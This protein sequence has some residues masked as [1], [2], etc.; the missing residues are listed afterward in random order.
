MEHL[1]KLSHKTNGRKL[2]SIVIPIIFSIWLEQKDY[3]YVYVCVCVYIY[4]VF[5][6]KIYPFNNVENEEI[7]VIIKYLQLSNSKNIALHTKT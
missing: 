5:E 1:Q 3:I 4:K 6:K 7:I 2:Q